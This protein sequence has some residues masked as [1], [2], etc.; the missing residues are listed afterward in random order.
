MNVPIK[1]SDLEPF[2][3]KVNRRHYYIGHSIKHL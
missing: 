1:Q 3:Y 2:N